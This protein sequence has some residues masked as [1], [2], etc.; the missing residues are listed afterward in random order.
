MPCPAAVM[1]AILPAS[2]PLIEYPLAL[3]NNTCKKNRAAKTPPD[4]A[5]QYPAMG[6][7]PRL[8]RLKLV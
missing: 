8:L 6:L 1:N 2:L 4:V 7:K 5:L 3:S